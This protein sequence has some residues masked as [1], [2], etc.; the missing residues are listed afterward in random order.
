MQ[1]N[2]NGKVDILETACWALAFNC[3][4]LAMG[5]ADSNAALARLKRHTKT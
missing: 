4:C 1:E 2:A 5:D 3:L